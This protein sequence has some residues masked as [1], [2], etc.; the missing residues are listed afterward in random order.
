MKKTPIYL[1]ILLPILLIVVVAIG[2]VMQEKKLTPAQEFVYAKGEYMNYGTCESFL[3][4]DLFHKAQPAYAR[5]LSVDT[6]AQKVG[7]FIYNF[8]TKGSKPI[9]YEQLKS[10]NLSDERLSSEGYYVLRACMAQSFFALPIE[11]APGSGLC[12]GLKHYQKSLD[13]EH[14]KDSFVTFIAWLPGNK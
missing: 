7:F 3:E 10:L 4:K 8:T 1:V 12:L 13:I 11:P 9:S 2:V 5:N 14:D 6:C